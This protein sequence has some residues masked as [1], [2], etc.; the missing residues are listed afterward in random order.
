MKKCG[1]KRNL[2]GVC[3]CKRVSRGRKTRRAITDEPYERSIKPRYAVPRA[4][5]PEYNFPALDPKRPGQVLKPGVPN[6]STGFTAPSPFSRGA[7]SAFGPV[8]QAASNYL[9]EIAKTARLQNQRTMANMGGGGSAG[10]RSNI[11]VNGSVDSRNTGSV[12]SRNSNSAPLNDNVNVILPDGTYQSFRSPQ[13]AFAYATGQER[14]E[15]DANLAQQNLSMNLPQN[16]PI[17]NQQVQDNMN[18]DDDSVILNDDNN[19]SMQALADDD[20]QILDINNEQNANLDEL[21]NQQLNQ[22]Q[23][24]NNNVRLND[25][26]IY[27]VQRIVNADEKEQANF[28]KKLQADGAMEDFEKAFEVYRQNN[29]PRPNMNNVNPALMQNIEDFVQGIDMIKKES[30]PIPKLPPIPPS[31]PKLPPINF[32]SPPAAPSLSPISYLTPPKS[33]GSLSLSSSS[34]SDSSSSKSSLYPYISPTSSIFDPVDLSSVS[35]FSPKSLSPEQVREPTTP[36]LPVNL[37]PPPPPPNIPKLLPITYSGIGM[38]RNPNNASTSISSSAIGSNSSK[39][40]RG[41]GTTDPFGSPVGYNPANIPVPDGDVQMENILPEM[42]NISEEEDFYYDKQGKK[43]GKVDNMPAKGDWYDKDGY[44]ISIYDSDTETASSASTQRS[45]VDKQIAQNTKINTPKTKQQKREES[46]QKREEAQ[47][48]KEE[49]KQKKEDEKQKKQQEKQKKQQEQEQKI[50]M[51]L[52][53]K[54]TF[55]G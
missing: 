27:M 25:N 34:S 33:S 55:Y 42:E 23:N 26:D 15:A 16:P 50:A 37:P 14:F 38:M 7:T 35:S 44:G 41:T 18:L 51:R 54:N 49:E 21:I 53:E 5:K 29:F 52:K 28:M 47:K 8:L 9:N 22:S 43:V 10:S 36:P 13:Q 40:K 1:C 2:L 6:V 17:N 19:S 31:I 24:V 30:K 46:R 45:G 20:Q 32:Q 3:S 12:L 4:R 11:V 39:A 48:K